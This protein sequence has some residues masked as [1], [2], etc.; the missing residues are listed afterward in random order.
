[1]SK[2]FWYRIL[3]ILGLSLAFVCHAE[4]IGPAQNTLVVNIGVNGYPPYSI[5][6]PDGTVKGIFWDVLTRVAEKHNYRLLSAE[7]P[8]KRVDSFM[9]EHRVDVTMRAIEWTREPERFIFS[10]PVTIARD[11]V[12]TRTDKPLNITSPEDLAGKFIITHLGYTYPSVE[13]LFASGKTKRI[14]LLDESSMFRRLG[15]ADRFDGLIANYRTGLWTLRVHGW[16][17]RFRADPTPLN[18]TPYRFMFAPGWADFVTVL[19]DE[20]AAMKSS[21]ELQAILAAYE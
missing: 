4:Q 15:S 14:E 11:V 19:N 20:L 17:N 18:E 10:D 16:E 21:G 8:S 6:Q 5:K 2:V 1:M 3:V 9:L 7:I 12:F 13:H